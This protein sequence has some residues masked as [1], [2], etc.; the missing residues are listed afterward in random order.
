MHTFR[1][2]C[3]TDNYSSCTWRPLQCGYLLYAQPPIRQLQKQQ[4]INHYIVK[5][6][7]NDSQ[8][9][10][11]ILLSIICTFRSNSSGDLRVF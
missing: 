4:N 3:K 5:E 1:H 6:W 2:V 11:L 9:L 7:F 10:F 8:F